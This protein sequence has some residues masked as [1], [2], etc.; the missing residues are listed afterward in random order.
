MEADKFRN[1]VT[2]DESW[3][4]LEFQ[5]STKWSVSRED[6]PE[7]ARKQIDTKKF[8]L[9]VIWGVKGFHVVDFMNKSISPFDL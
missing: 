2:G 5:Y 9:T 1:I 4:T 8:T 6:V 3:F 7:R